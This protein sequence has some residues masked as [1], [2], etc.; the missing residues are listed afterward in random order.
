MDLAKKKKT[1]SVPLIIYRS[2]CGCSTESLDLSR[3]LPIEAYLYAAAKQTNC[4]CCLRA[5]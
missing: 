4:S 1:I 5:V 3:L 2:L